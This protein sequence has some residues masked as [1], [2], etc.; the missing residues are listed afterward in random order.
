MNG[1]TKISQPDFPRLFIPE[2]MSKFPATYYKVEQ[3]SLWLA[4][5]YIPENV[6]RK[7]TQ[8]TADSKAFYTY[9]INGKKFI[10]FLQNDI[11]TAY[12]KD[13]SNTFSKLGKLL[14]E[15][16]QDSVHLQLSLQSADLAAIIQKGKG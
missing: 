10:S 7:I 1:F 16:D 4:N 8:R 3:N 6:L 14:L 5:Q 11:K 2:G 13:L 9:Y 15:I 12:K